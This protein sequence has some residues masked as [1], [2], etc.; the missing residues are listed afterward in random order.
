MT[1]R[2]REVFSIIR[3]NPM[4][5]HN[6]IAK[7]LG[8]T[9]STVA[10]YIASIMQQGYIAGKGYVISEDYVVCLGA[11][12]VDVFGFVPGNIIP[13]DKN[14]G[15]RVRISSGGAARN[16]AENLSRLGYGVKM[17]TVIGADSF[18]EKLMKDC[19]VAGMDMSHV[20]VVEGENTATYVCLMKDNGEMYAGMTDVNIT[21]HQTVDYYK[22]H[23]H[24]ILNAKAIVMTAET[25]DGVTAYLHE[26][27]PSIPIIGD[28]S[29]LGAIPRFQKNLSLYHTVKA[30][31]MEAEA[32]TGITYQSEEDLGAISAA[33]LQAG[34]KRVIITL[35]SDGVY[36]RD[37]HR[38]VRKKVKQ[39]IKPVNS[40]GAGDA[41]TAGFVYCILRG[42]D[43]EDALSFAMAASVVA[44]GHE[45]SINPNICTSLVRET[46]AKLHS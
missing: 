4:I 29:T 36:Y 14:P 40:T 46:M 16:I 31:S 28:V 7:Q 30:N 5:S 25:T 38:I 22:Q 43:I 3:K 19:N 6:E 33:I 42:D 15:G 34:V 11:A 39:V 8:I 10:V 13:G 26:T 41:F 27:Y 21:K 12:I 1:D 24:T 35:G 20:K 32:L 44:L 45:Q 18:G 17:L 37:E 9:R 23:H 2:E